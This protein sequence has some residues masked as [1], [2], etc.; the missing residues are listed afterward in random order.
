M[1]RLAASGVAAALAIAVAGGLHAHAQAAPEPGDLAARIQ[2][3]YTTVRDFTADFTDTYQSPVQP[4]R[5][6]EHGKV[7]V[8]KPLRMRW[9]YEGPEKKELVADG[10]RLWWY[11]PADKHVDVSKIPAGDDASTGLL[12]LAGKGDLVRDFQHAMPASQPAGAW[13]LDL[14]PKTHDADFRSLALIVDRDTLKL[15]G[16]VRVDADGGT[17]AFD[18]SGL[19]EN[20]G[21]KDQDFIF[22]PPKG[23]DIGG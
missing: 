15:K 4:Q 17:S 20:V 18:F 7:S 12:F 1:T 13:R 6:V 22:V 11:V 5:I 9:L 21:L 14:L 16:L 8:K 3:H 10:T 19:R 2:Q 23:V